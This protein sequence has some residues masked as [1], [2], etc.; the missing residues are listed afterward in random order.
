LKNPQIQQRELENFA[1]DP[2]TP[3]G[4]LRSIS[5][6]QK[7]MKDYSMK[8]AICCNPKTP[9]DISMKWFRFLTVGDL[10]KLAKS[11]SVP[12][13]LVAAVR[14]QLMELKKRK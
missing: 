13:A 8:R 7:W 14:K 3:K 6:T 12:Q 2:N 1:L 4:V 9:L 5:D 11:K 10:N